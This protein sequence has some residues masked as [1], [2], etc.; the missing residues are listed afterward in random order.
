MA[1]AANGDLYLSTVGNFS[2][3][4]LPS[5]TLTG[6]NED[7]FVCTSPTLTSGTITGCTYSSTLYFDGSTIGSAPG[8]TPNNVDAIDL[9]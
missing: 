4:L 5:G 8:L 1:R 6:A 3:P 9:P 2:V 7:V